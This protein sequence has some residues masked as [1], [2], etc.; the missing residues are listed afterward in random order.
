MSRTIL[1]EEFPRHVAAALAALGVRNLVLSLQDPS[2]PSAPGEDGGRGSPYAEGGLRFLEFARALGFTGIQLGP[3]GQTS[4]DNASPYDGSLF[5]RN[6]LNVA[7]GP[8]TREEPWGAL[9]RPERVAAFWAE[10]G[11]TGERVRH[12]AFFRAHGELLDEAWAT[13]Q[14]KR[15]QAVPGSAV[16]RLAERFA[17]FQHEHQAWLE[18]DA[19]YDVLCAEHGRDWW[20]QW[21]SEWDRRLWH[22]RPGEVEAFAHR[23]RVLRSKYAAPVEAYA[24]RQFLVHAQ[25]AALREHTAAWGLKLYGDL[26]IGYSPRDAWAWQGLFLGAYLMGA[27]PSRTNPEGQPW[28]YP[29]LDPAQYHAAPDAEDAYAPAP[30][31]GPV[32]W[33]MAARMDKM[34]AEYDGLRIDHPHG[35]VCPWVYR[36]GAP[37]PVRAVQAGARLFASP[38]LPDHPELARWAL[39]P[40]E[41]LNRAVPRYA[42]GWVRELGTAQVSRYS[43]LFDAIV[44][45]AHARGRDVS[46]LLC[47]VLS[48]MPY[49]LERVLAQYGLGRFRVTQKADLNNPQDVYRSENA[50]PADWIMLGNHDTKTI[51]ALAERW[52]AGDEARAQAD[53]LA[54]RLHPEAAGR[55]DFA[56]RL[57]AEPGLLV[58]A[59]FAD[60]FVSQAQNVMVFFADLFGLTAT[61][62]APGTVNDENW[63][64]R[65]PRDY[66]EVYARG[67]GANAVLNLPR[68]LALALRAGDE[69]SRA[70]HGP[71]IE[72]LERLAEG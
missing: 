33:F 17:A 4:E 31:P 67:L 26:Q 37:E 61:Y 29:V 62:N 16:S 68:A 28:N 43:A 32:L 34:L 30:R 60:L 44:A 24:F 8:L 71:L 21:P 56:R 65:V 19:L 59:K 47:E 63:S 3:Q 64:L 22:P 27:P 70:R 58:Q 51:W 18:R 2:F 10:H 46:D 6:V 25:H 66:R 52:R 42:D 55:E 7:P 53:Y 12:R 35:L 54:G 13:F 48:T 50:R 41:G 69:P 9:L 39:V 49:P 72:A 40:P 57:L 38:D 11:G 20:R 15:A 1:S 14:L 36:A 45:A 5:S 23:R